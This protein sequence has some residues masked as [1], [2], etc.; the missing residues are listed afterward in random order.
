MKEMVIPNN[1]TNHQTI[2]C[3]PPVVHVPLIEKKY[4]LEPPNA[5]LHPLT[6]PPPFKIGF[7]GWK[8]DTSLAHVRDFM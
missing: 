4:V 1:F 6:P 5:A 3:V 7:T 8:L 2:L